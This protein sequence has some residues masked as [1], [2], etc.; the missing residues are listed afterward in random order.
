MEIGQCFM[1]DS[2]SAPEWVALGGRGNFSAQTLFGQEGFSIFL[3]GVRKMKEGRNQC[4]DSLSILWCYH[5]PL[6]LLLEGK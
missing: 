4:T 3:A 5:T 2:C 1:E 6:F